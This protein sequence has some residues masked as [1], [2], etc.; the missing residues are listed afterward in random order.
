M[1]FLFKK[2]RILRSLLRLINRYQKKI[3]LIV[4]MIRPGVKT[5]ILSLTLTL[6]FDT[7]FSM[8]PLLRREQIIKRLSQASTPLSASLLAKELSVSRQVIV[9]DVAILRAAGQDIMATPKGY[10]LKNTLGL[11]PVE[12]TIA[13]KHDASRLKEELYTIVDCGGT[14]LDVTVEH[15]VYGQLTGQLNLSSRYEVDRFLAKL[16][17]NRVPP[18]SQLTNGI[19]LHKIGCQSGEVFDI[20]KEQL[21]SLNILL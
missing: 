16:E 12:K 3:F 10:F 7:I 17:E 1:S 8:N 21:S 6:P 15:M 19:H 13:V 5:P 2:S 20:I 9:G 18:L 11:F 14:V 4:A